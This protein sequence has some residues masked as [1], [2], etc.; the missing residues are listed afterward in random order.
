M[1]GVKKRDGIEG[2]LIFGKLSYVFLGDPS[3]DCLLKKL[4]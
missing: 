1:V 3:L 2:T 4:C